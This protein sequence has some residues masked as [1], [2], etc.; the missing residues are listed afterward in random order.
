MGRG[1]LTHPVPQIILS[2][3]LNFI[4][5]YENTFD[6]FS[7]LLHILTKLG[8]HVWLIDNHWNGLKWFQFLSCGSSTCY[9]DRLHDF[10]VTISRCYKDVSSFACTMLSFFDLWSK[11]HQVWINRHLLSL[12]FCW[13]PFLYVSYFNVRRIRHWICSWWV[14]CSKPLGC[15]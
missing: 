3:I 13:S 9:S 10:S 6:T 8:C 15:S 5:V 14:L 2:C 12:R 1:G 4:A 11:W 7:F